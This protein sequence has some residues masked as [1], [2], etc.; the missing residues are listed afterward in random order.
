MIAAIIV[1]SLV[2]VPPQA[3]L[4]GGD[5]LGHLAAYGALMLWF[6]QLYAR[7]LGF[8]LGFAAMGAALEFAQGATGYRSFDVL[9][10]AAN[11]A[12]VALG[13]GLALLLPR[14]LPR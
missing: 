2:P 14:L 12:G 6:G 13:W 4:G 5:K 1:L 11:A 10:M 8:A 3:D 9:D 7:R